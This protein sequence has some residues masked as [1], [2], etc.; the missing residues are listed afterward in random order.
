MTPGLY[1]RFETSKGEI[2]CRLF[3][4]E[5]PVAVRNFGALAQGIT[6]WTDPKTKKKTRRK[7]YD[8]LAFYKVIPDELIA[9]GDPLGS[10]E[11]GGRGGGAP[12]P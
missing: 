3:A 11:S 1:A 2:V 5:A 9:S 6:E 7:F 4:D 8:G 10:G 12:W